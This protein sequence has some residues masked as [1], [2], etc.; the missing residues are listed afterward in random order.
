MGDESLWDEFVEECVDDMQTI[1]VLEGVNG[2]VREFETWLYANNY[3]DENNVR[4]IR[5]TKTAF[6]E[7]SKQ[8]ER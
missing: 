4:E 1:L 5:M 2:I 8:K 7:Q 6:A 3:V